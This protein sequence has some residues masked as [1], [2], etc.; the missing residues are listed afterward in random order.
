MLCRASLAD[1]T[2]NDEGKGRLTLSHE[3]ACRL[4]ATWSNP[5]S[6]SPTGSV[7]KPLLRT[8]ESPTTCVARPG[9][10]AR[11]LITQVKFSANWQ[12]HLSIL[13]GSSG[14]DPCPNPSLFTLS[15]S[16]SYTSGALLEEGR[17]HCW[18]LSLVTSRRLP[19][20]IG[21]SCKAFSPSSSSLSLNAVCRRQ[22]L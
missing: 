14:D 4:S 11:Q 20:T 6:G 21:S 7:T 18:S 19:I 15:L 16:F 10:I 22:R 9:P 5:M 17:D 3:V 2:D 8:G 13:L 1:S 12:P